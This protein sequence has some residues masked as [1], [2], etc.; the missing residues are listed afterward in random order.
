VSETD[1]VTVGFANNRSAL[2]STQ[3]KTEMGT[4]HMNTVMVFNQ[5]NKP[6][7]V[8]FA[9]KIFCLPDTLPT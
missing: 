2:K 9:F 3:V 4:Y 6:M 5:P 8:H 1:C 7:T